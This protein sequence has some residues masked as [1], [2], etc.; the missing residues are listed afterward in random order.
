MGTTRRAFDKSFGSLV[1]VFG[2]LDESLLDVE[3][4]ERSRMTLHLAVEELFTNMV[5]YNSGES[6]EIAIQVIT[7]DNSVRIELIDNDTDPFD[8]AT[9]DPVDVGRP[10][11]ER[12]RGGLGLH[13]VRSLVDTMDYQYE[14][15][16]MRVSVT[17]TLE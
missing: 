4:D 2:F 8:P 14:G 5:K 13:L 7:D 17:T 12:K 11:E 15:R 6:R 16:E 1:D 3:V 10:I 9:A